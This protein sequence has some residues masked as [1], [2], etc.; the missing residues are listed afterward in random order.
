MAV[1]MWVETAAWGVTLNVV[2]LALRLA[3]VSFSSIM[4]KADRRSASVAE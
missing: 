1:L 4:A 3:S 2:L